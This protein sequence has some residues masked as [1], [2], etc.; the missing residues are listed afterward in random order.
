MLGSLLILSI[1]LLVDTGLDIKY[2]LHLYLYQSYTQS[3]L[4]HIN[5]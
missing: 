5:K 4:F 1:I 3:C 2:A